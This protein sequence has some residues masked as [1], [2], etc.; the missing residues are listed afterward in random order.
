MKPISVRFQCFGPYMQEQFVDFTKLEKNG[1]FLICG[2]TGAGKTTILDAM[3]YALYGRS[4]GGLRGEL[5]VMR[6]KQ[7]ADTDETFVEYI[8][9]SG[10]ERYR[11]Y[12]GF[13]PKKRRKA[14]ETPEKKLL[15]EYNATCECQILKDGTFVPLP[16]AKDKPSFLNEMANQLIGLT[17]EQFRQ[18]IILPQGQFER[19]LVSGSEEKEKILVTLF[20][21]QRWQK[22][23]VRLYEQADA[24]SKQLDQERMLIQDKLNGYGCQGLE[25]LREM[26]AEESVQVAELLQR[27]NAMTKE[28]QDF[29]QEWDKL[30]LENREFEQLDELKKRLNA[31]LPKVSAADQEEVI[32]NWADAAERITGDYHQY[33]LAHQKL[34]REQKEVEKAQ[35]AVLGAQRTAQEVQQR[36][37]CHE[38][39]RQRHL[40]NTQDL[41][42]LNNAEGVYQALGQK[43]QQGHQAK[44]ALQDAKIRSDKAEEKRC[45]ARSQWE[46]AIR[47]QQQA[48]ETFEHV[49]ML[50]LSGIGSILA[51]KLTDGAP[52]P[53]CGSLSHPAPARPAEGHVT[54]DELKRCAQDRTAAIRQE[55]A[56]RKGY[57]EADEDYKAAQSVLTQKQQDYAV[58]VT[59]YKQVKAQRIPGIDNLQQLLT[60]AQGL[61]K[62]IG[63]FERTETELQQRMQDAQ[64]NLQAS[65]MGL[66]RSRKNLEAAS[67]EFD[68]HRCRWEQ[69]RTDAGFQ[70]DAQYQAACMDTAALQ[71]RRTA[72]IQFRTDLANA[73]REVAEKQA[74]LQ[75]RQQ[76][77][78]QGAK[79]RLEQAQKQQS[80][81]NEVYVLRNSRRKTMEK[82]AEDLEKRT[83]AYGEKRAKC[84]EAVVFAKRIRGDYGISLQRY[85]LGVM[86]TS[87]TAAANQL[88]RTVY[89]GRYQLY[90][91]NESS[92][93]ARKRGLELE[94]ADHNGRRSVTTLSGGE[95]FLLS[96]SLAIGLS[97]VVQAQGSG[98]RLE[99]M[100]IDEGFGSLD[101]KSIDDALEILNGIR[102][103]SGMV[104]IIS[105]VERLAETIPAKIQISKTKDGSVCKITC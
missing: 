48:S 38:N 33:E 9:E 65:R 41:V 76:P 70:N 78:V 19:L 71:R 46:Q 6:C 90:R 18:V 87:I 72:L 92:G 52:C 82:D 50:Y 7:A 17:Y 26:T 103:S 37:A 68:E 1:L 27:L 24:Q 25:Q 42:L 91:T 47:M 3:C 98:V 51:E 31:L 14:V 29:K 75:D 43:E 11:F 64:G 54:E 44:A 99:A 94:V 30:L 79:Q 84:D 96:L 32:L 69:A 16:D 8:F 59:E 104:G 61:E 77:D 86:L 66:E 45:H 53:V 89:G 57:M 40:R 39:D 101:R 55:D 4:S 60:A 56:A 85:V 12:R 102:R 5:P 58:A 28:V 21:A 83:K 73:A 80:D 100:F 35:Q 67:E 63:D 34:L 15:S 2:E 10:A 13:K 97:T 81:L 49:Q 62:A 74:Q 23:A 88:L 36:Q 22:I 20:H 95:K 93:S 105:H